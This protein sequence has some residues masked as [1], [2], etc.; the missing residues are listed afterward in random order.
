MEEKQETN[1]TEKLNKLENNLFKADDWWGKHNITT[2]FILLAN[3]LMLMGLIF[4]EVLTAKQ[5]PHFTEMLDTIGNI[6]L[7]TT[8]TILIGVNGIKVFLDFKGKKEN[9]Q[10]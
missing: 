3:T 4:F 2:R 1:Y 9:P 10:N 6:V 8:I 5:I 7:Y